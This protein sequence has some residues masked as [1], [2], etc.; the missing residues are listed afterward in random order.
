MQINTFA[1]TLPENAFSVT[2]TVNLLLLTNAVSTPARV[3]VGY[4]ADNVLGPLNTY[5]AALASLSLTLFAWTAVTSGPGM[6]VWAAAFGITNGAAQA[7]YVSGLASLTPDP[8]KLGI[9]LG[10]VCGIVAFA[11]L[12]GP[13]TAGAI[14]DATG[15]SYRWAQI[16]GGSV[17]L[18]AML[19]IMAARWC[20]E[21]SLWARV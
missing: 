16:W 4:V 6:W 3:L 13:P 8:K 12:A 20:L 14:L 15:G 21:K 19:F 18:L 10:M 17:E 9:R 5:I 11:S 7:A 1:L 2:T